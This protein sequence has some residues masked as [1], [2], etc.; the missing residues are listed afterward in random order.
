MPVS[1]GGGL[2]D[3]GLVQDLQ[4]AAAELTMLRGVKFHPEE[5]EA[6]IAMRPRHGGLVTLCQRRHSR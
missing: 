4:L 6:R 1:I 3:V 5:P 2:V